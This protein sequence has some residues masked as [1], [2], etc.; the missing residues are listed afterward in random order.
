MKKI[1][2]RARWIVPSACLYS[3]GGCVADPQMFDFVRTEIA[4]LTADTVGQI[5]TIFVQ[6][7]T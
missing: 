4:R 3:L 1:W 2:I 7:T 5:F 6:A